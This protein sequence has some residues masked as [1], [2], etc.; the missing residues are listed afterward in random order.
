MFGNQPAYKWQLS[1]GKDIS[2]DEVLNLP[3]CSVSSIKNFYA[4]EVSDPVELQIAIHAGE[5]SGRGLM[6]DMLDHSNDA[7]SSDP[8]TGRFGESY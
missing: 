7:I 4:A 5:V 8:L 2:L 1:A 6:S 3:I